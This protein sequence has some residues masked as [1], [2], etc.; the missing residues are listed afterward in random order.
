MS[1]STFLV[2]FHYSSE[3]LVLFVFSARMRTIFVLN[4]I[5]LNYIEIH[6]YQKSYIC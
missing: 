3:E 5:K 6:I 4:E 1:Q 2:I